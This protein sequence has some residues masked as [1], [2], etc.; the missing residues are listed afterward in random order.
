MYKITFML[1]EVYHM[2]SNYS[3]SK[4]SEILKLFKETT[5]IYLKPDC[6]WI[7]SKNEIDKL[8]NLGILSSTELNK[9]GL[10]NCDE[11]IGYIDLVT[12][13]IKSYIPDFE[14]EFDDDE[15]I[16]ELW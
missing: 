11:A 8:L 6:Q 5:G 7:I 12:R 3:G 13:I 2:R 16:I 9:S 15:E 4:V 1:D 10:Y 14:W